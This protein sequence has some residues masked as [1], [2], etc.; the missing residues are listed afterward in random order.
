MQIAAR[1]TS[2]PKL[3]TYGN[4]DDP[5]ARQAHVEPLPRTHAR[6]YAVRG[7]VPSTRGT[8]RNLCASRASASVRGARARRG[9]GGGVQ[10]PDARCPPGPRGAGGRAAR[11]RPRRPAASPA[12]ARNR[13]LRL[14]SAKPIRGAH[15]SRDFLPAHNHPS[16]AGLDDNAKTSN[17]V[18]QRLQEHMAPQDMGKML[19]VNM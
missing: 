9:P 16:S 10:A 18:Q 6:Q 2:I 13:Y 4:A 7:A 5:L 19:L 17:E 1:N 14:L 12:A 15:H 3:T 11:H 8:A